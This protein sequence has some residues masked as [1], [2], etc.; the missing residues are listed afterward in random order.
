M[1][2]FLFLKRPRTEKIIISSDFQFEKVF[3][4]SGIE[5]AFDRDV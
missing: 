1:A 5:I 4:L 2:K 3:D